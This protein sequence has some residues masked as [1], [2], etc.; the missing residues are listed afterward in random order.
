MDKS[1]CQYHHRSACNNKISICRAD[2][3]MSMLMQA[4]LPGLSSQLQLILFLCFFT[5]FLFSILQY[6]LL[7][8]LAV[9]LL[10]Q[11]E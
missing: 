8:G 6:V 9:F 2:Q 11:R 1:D 10:F 7:G 4:S 3:L 5:I